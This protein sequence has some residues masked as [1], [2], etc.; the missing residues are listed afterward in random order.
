M[1]VT[2]LLPLEPFAT[3]Q[4]QRAIGDHDPN[5]LRLRLDP[6]SDPIGLESGMTVWISR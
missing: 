2:E 5:T 6:Q 4:A 3:R 1:V